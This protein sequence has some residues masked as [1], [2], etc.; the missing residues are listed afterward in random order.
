[1]PVRNFPKKKRHFSNKIESMVEKFDSRWCFVSYPPCKIL[2]IWFKVMLCINCI[3]S[4]VTYLCLFLY[5][6]TTIIPL[7]NS[8]FNILCF[9]YIHKNQTTITGRSEHKYSY[10]LSAILK[11]CFLYLTPLLL[12]RPVRY[13]DSK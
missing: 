2:L 10:N 12:T 3:N 5:T 9:I 6:Y 4:E 11:K 1:M 7:H 8:N 13:K